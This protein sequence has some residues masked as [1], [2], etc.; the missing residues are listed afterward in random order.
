MIP[1]IDMK[2]PLAGPHQGTPVARQTPPPATPQ[3]STPIGNV[4]SKPNIFQRPGGAV[5]PPE[6]VKPPPVSS[7]RPGIFRML[8]FVGGFLVVA[9]ILLLAV[10]FFSGAMQNSGGGPADLVYWGL[11]EDENVINGVIADFQKE[12]PTIKVTYKKQSIKQ[13]RESLVNRIAGVPAADA[14]DVFRYH[15]SWVPMLRDYLAP[16]PQDVYSTSD[17]EKTFYP[18]TKQDLKVGSAYVGIPLEIDT[19]VL[20]I[21]EDIFKA[22]GVAPPTSW[23]ELVKAADALRVMDSE[24]HIQTA[25]VALGTYDNVDHASDILAMMMMQNGVDLKKIDK[26]LSADGSN[27]GE[28]TLSYYTSFAKGSTRVWDDTLDSSTLA[29]SKGKLAMYFG[30][31]WRMFEIKAMNP[32]LHFKIIPVPQLPKRTQVTYASYWVEGV[33]KNSKKQKQAFA[34][35]KYL[36]KPEVLQKL[37][38]EQAKVRQFGEPYSRVDMAQTLK[39]TPNIGVVISQAPY[40]RSWYLSSNTYDNGL[41]DQMIV[42]IAD[43]IRS[44][45]KNTAPMSALETAAK[46]INSLATK[47]GF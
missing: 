12:N 28:L 6:G 18:T 27:L 8:P 7:G 47:Y 11:W 32:S 23:D 34:F 10:R 2:V 22:G 24:N 9:I 40:A 20:Y 45:N 44:V 15:N 4:P 42:Y 3:G 41:N 46:G 19:L 21:N 25:G 35:L 16:V 31:S 13:Y 14:P 17:F 43:A 29:F 37:Y 39:N 36:S 1:Y 5:P 30:Y 26:S 33:A 38:A